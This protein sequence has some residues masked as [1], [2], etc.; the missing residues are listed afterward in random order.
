MKIGHLGGKIDKIIERQ[1]ARRTLPSN[2]VKRPKNPFFLPMEFFLEHPQTLDLIRSTLN[3]SQI[4]KR[5]YFEPDRIDQLVKR[6]HSREFISLKQVMA[7]V[8]LELWHMVFVD[9]HHIS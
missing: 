2:V 8:I 5:G 7:L 1:L 6:M 4:K 3:K 9:G